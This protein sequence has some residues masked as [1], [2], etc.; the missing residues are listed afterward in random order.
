MLL[1]VALL[2][3]DLVPLLD[4]CEQFRLGRLIRLQAEHIECL[5]TEHL[6]SQRD[7]FSIS[8]L[9]L[10]IAAEPIL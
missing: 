2:V 9:V 3:D 4:H 10:L 7:D 8:D 1:G 5:V 6:Q